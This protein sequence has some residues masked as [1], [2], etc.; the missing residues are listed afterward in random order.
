[1]LSVERSWDR[2]IL[3]GSQSGFAGTGEG[4]IDGIRFPTDFA[5][6]GDGARFPRYLS[7]ICG[8]WTNEWHVDFCK[9]FARNDICK[10]GLACV[11]GFVKDSSTARRPKDAVF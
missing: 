3:S 1:M 2:M 10:E 9:V 4:H 7:S 6:D 5:G 8:G 11:D